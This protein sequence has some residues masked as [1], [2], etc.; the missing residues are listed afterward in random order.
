MILLTRQVLKGAFWAMGFVVS[1]FL[2][3][4]L[5]KSLFDCYRGSGFLGFTLLWSCFGVAVYLCYL[6]DG[7]ERAV[8]VSI[9]ILIMHLFMWLIGFYRPHS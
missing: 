2:I 9:V 1:S 4:V 7:S 8:T 6:M 5:G 3:R